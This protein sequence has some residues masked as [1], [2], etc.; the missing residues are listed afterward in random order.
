M[1]VIPVMMAT[2]PVRLGMS[3]SLIC[4]AVILFIDLE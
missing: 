1:V 3:S 2:F 4:I